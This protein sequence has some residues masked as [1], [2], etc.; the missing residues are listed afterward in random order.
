[1]DGLRRDW[2]RGCLGAA[3]AGTLTVWSVLRQ[4]ASP[5]PEGVALAFDLL[6]LGVVYG[7]VDGFLL[8]VLSRTLSGPPP[9]NQWGAPT[10]I[11]EGSPTTRG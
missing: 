11:G 1:M 9:A 7:L 2:K 5:R 8:S 3:V 10:H 4:P 6:W